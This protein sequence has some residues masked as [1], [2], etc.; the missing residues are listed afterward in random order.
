VLV[1]IMNRSY[2]ACWKW[3]SK[4]PPCSDLSDNVESYRFQQSFPTCREKKISTCS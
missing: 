4:E 2:L 3:M 1:L